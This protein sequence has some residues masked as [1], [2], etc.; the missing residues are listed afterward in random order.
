MLLQQISEKILT[1]GNLSFA[2]FP[3]FLFTKHF[4]ILRPQAYHIQPHLTGPFPAVRGLAYPNLTNVWGN[5]STFSNHV[6]DRAIV[7]SGKELS[8]GMEVLQWI[9]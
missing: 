3:S 5:V 2:G 7:S 4:V 8:N 6:N 9:Q 1:K